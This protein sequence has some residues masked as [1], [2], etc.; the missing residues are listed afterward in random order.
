MALTPSFG[1]VLRFFSSRSPI[2]SPIK[3]PPA[4][5]ERVDNLAA[6]SLG[7][8]LPSRSIAPKSALIGDA[9]HRVHPRAGQG[10]N[11]GFGDV[12]C[13]VSLLEESAKRGEPLLGYEESVLSDYETERLRHNLTTMA[14]IDGLQ[15]LY[16]T[17]NTVAILARSLGFQLFDFNSSVKILAM[18]QAGR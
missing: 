9:A 14:A 16:C 4:S 8:G 12:S 17:D 3:G 7:C 1:I 6:F 10:V 13:L 5:I 2:T 11:L 15:K 18:N